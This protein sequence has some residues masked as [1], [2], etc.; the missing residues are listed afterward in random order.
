M[1]GLGKPR[2]K[3]GEFLDRHKVKHEDVSRVTGLHRDTV[4]EACSLP[5]YKPRNST[6]NLL[7][8]AA[9]QL[10]GKNV[11]KDDFWA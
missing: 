8:M 2:S 7:V 9:K 10:T 3:Y 1:F 6:I 4:S 11:G 5:K